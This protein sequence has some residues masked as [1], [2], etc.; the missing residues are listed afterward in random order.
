MDFQLG[1]KGDQGENN[2]FKCTSK[3]EAEVIKRRIEEDKAFRA[4][5]KARARKVEK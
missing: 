3:V 2:M 5:E 1:G 4:A